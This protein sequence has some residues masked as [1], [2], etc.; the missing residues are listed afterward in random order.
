[1]LADVPDRSPGHREEFFGPVALIWTARDI[2]D[3]I[4]IANDSS[5]GIA[6]SAW[7]VDRGEQQRFVS[8]VQTGMMYI[9][10]SVESIPEIPCGG[11]KS[12][13]YG[14]E[15]GQFGPRTFVN[16]KAVWISD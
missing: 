16:A 8:E 10:K 12:S 5:L 13:G 6:V 9:N 15:L 2:E 3:A 4:C 11:T 14:R 7:T 1:L